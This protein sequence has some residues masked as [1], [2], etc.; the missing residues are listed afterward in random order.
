MSRRAAT[1]RL[2]DAPLIRTA[3]GCI[4]FS[5]RCFLWGF[6]SR[7]PRS[8]R[9]TILSVFRVHLAYYVFIQVGFVRAYERPSASGRRNVGVD[10][11]GGKGASLCRR[12][13]MLAHGGVQASKREG[14]ALE[15]RCRCT[16]LGRLLK[17]GCLR[18]PERVMYTCRAGPLIGIAC[19][20]PLLN[21]RKE[22]WPPLSDGF[23]RY[24]VDMTSDR[25][26]ADQPVRTRT[27]ESS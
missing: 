9:A 4:P 2:T 15:T 19:C 10:G 21:R 14:F 13:F 5:Y 18:M 6:S 7:S 11:E 3:V 26:G 25:F 20:G 12:T 27:R 17:G 24:A 1:A 8:P 23:L 16:E 22:G